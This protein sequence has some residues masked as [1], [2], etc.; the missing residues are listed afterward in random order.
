MTCSF[1]SASPMHGASAVLVAVTL[2]ACGAASGKP[3]AELSGDASHAGDAGTSQDGSAMTEAGDSA[4]GASCHA[5]SDCAGALL[6]DL[7][8]STCVACRVTSDCGGGDICRA[9]VCQAGM[10]CQS[11]LQCKALGM[12]CDVAG[13]RCVECN[14]AADCSGN[15]GGTSGQA[16]LGQSCLDTTACTSS[17]GCGPGLVCAAAAPPAWPTAFL[18]MGCSECASNA[19]CPAAEACQGGLCIKACFLAAAKCGTV[20]GAECGSCP[21]HG[22]CSSTHTTC[23]DAVGDLDPDV[24]VSEGLVVTEDAV[25]SAN[26]SAV[27]RTDRTTHKTTTVAQASDI[28]NGLASNSTD[29]FW[30]VVNTIYKMPLAGGTPT[31]VHTF[32]AEDDCYGVAADD[33]NAYCYINQNSPS[34]FG[35]YQIPLSG[36]GSPW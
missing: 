25:F 22:Q 26:S 7:T 23:L 15:Q 11:D 13:G 9:G 6:C 1:F 27:F 34:W 30:A 10:S 4:P 20:D 36:S 14:G 8:T 17:L 33:Q 21:D 3:G 12:V 29:L 28:L 24:A 2:G 31:K 35:I 19:D 16:C 18:G 5:S 32:A